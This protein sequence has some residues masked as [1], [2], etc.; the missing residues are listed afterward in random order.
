L[1]AIHLDGRHLALLLALSLASGCSNGGVI[2]GDGYQ[3]PVPAD[4]DVADDDDMVDDDDV[5]DDDD[6]VPPLEQVAGTDEDPSA[7]IYDW[8]SIPTFEITL[9]GDAYHALQVDPYTY[10]EGEFTWEGVTYGP[11]GVRLKGQGS[12]QSID[13]KPAFKIKFNEYVSGGRFL[14]RESLTLNNM[15]WDYSMLHERLA[16]LIYRAA[17]VPASRNNHALV[18]VNGQF[19]GL[20]ANTESTEQQLI[21]QWFDD[22]GGSMFEGW[23]VDFYPWYVDSFQLDWGPDDY[24]NIT[25]LA[26]ALQIPG[27]AGLTEAEDHVH[28]DS[29]LRYWAVGAVVAQYDAYPYSSPGD[30]FQLY[31]D[32]TT[33]SLWFMPWGT[34]ETFYYPDNS[35]DAVNGILAQRCLEVPDCRDAWEAHVWEVMDLV[36]AMD[37]VALLDEVIDEIEPHVQADP[38]RP[39]DVNT[40]NSYQQTAR[41]LMV[42]RRAT[43]EWQLGAP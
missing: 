20:Y 17:G 35:V 16:Y 40:V 1:S 23:D 7:V 26:E 3:P 9:Q 30:D 13:D 29:F 34:D 14:G 24:T 43:L 11:V 31:D 27:A 33:S 39:Y 22:V 25:G 18:Y 36:E 4:D 37:W 41:Q 28:L 38:R 2:H 42:G 32:P 12:F 5:T 8:G 6:S 10:T 19:Y 21:A 15:V